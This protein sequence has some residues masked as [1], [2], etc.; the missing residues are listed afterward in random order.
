M[1]F[2]HCYPKMYEGFKCVIKPFGA[3]PQ[4]LAGMPSDAENARLHFPVVTRMCQL[5]DI[6]SLVVVY[7]HTTAAGLLCLSELQ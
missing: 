6:G 4:G 3:K 2:L 5:Q 1:A 7:I